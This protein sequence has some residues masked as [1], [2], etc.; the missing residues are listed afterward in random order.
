MWSISAPS[1]PVMPCRCQRLPDCPGEV[2]Q[3]FDVG[4]G[5]SSWPWSSTRKNQLPPQ[6]MS[7]T[8][9]AMPGR[10]SDRNILARADSWERSARTPRRRS[11]RA[12]TTPTGVSI[13]CS[14]GSMRPRW[15]SVATQADRA[16][17]AHTQKP[18]LLKKMTPAAHDVRRL[19]QQRPHQHVRAARLVDDRGPEAVVRRSERRACRCATVPTPRSGPPAI[20]TRVGSPPV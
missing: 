1:A 8:T 10:D 20:T 7:P 15:A 6:A 17:A 19:G 18:T 3:R 13:R 14:P 12:V 4:Q 16:V 9:R 11:K 2:R 5:L